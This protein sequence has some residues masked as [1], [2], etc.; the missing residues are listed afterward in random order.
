MACKEGASEVFVVF[1]PYFPE[2]KPLYMW[3]YERLRRG[4][5]PIQNLIFYTGQ[6]H[7]KHQMTLRALCQV[8]DFD[9]LRDT[10][11]LLTN[12]EALVQK[13]EYKTTVQH[14][15]INQAT[16]D[17]QPAILS[18]YLQT[19]K[20]FYEPELEKRHVAYALQS[21][22]RLQKPGMTPQQASLAEVNVYFSEPER[23]REDSDSDAST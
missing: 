10:I 14:L 20:K 2:Q 21:K 6:Y 8:S 7:E 13:E 12:D 22:S 16:L 15:G 11:Q 9:T 4:H 3:V 5:R 23:E 1:A 19:M 18:S 17:A